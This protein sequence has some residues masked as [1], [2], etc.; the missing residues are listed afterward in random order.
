MRMRMAAWVVACLA[1]LLQGGCLGP[2]GP[3]PWEVARVRKQWVAYFENGYGRTGSQTIRHFDPSVGTAM[4]YRLWQGQYRGIPIA[5]YSCS[6]SKAWG[7]DLVWL[8]IVLATEKAGVR[9]SK[10]YPYYS[11]PPIPRAIVREV[12]EH[13]FPPGEID[14]T[15]ILTEAHRPNSWDVRQVRVEV[16]DEGNGRLGFRINATEKPTW[17]AFD[18]EAALKGEA[19]SGPRAIESLSYPSLT[20]EE[21]AKVTIAEL[22]KWD[23]TSAR[24]WEGF[25]STAEMSQVDHPMW[26]DSGAVKTLL[27]AV[28]VGPLAHAIRVMSRRSAKEPG[29]L[30]RLESIDA[31]LLGLARH[32]AKEVRHAFCQ[33]LGQTELWPRNVH[34]LEPLLMSDDRTVQGHVLSAFTR[35]KESPRRLDRVR[36][37][38]A[39]EDGSV[40]LMAQ[41]VLALPDD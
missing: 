38:A 4:G 10:D 33:L 24:W 30:L 6:F 17:A 32:D 23:T 35:R 39:S 26:D 21:F 7:S 41:R 28:P 2:F 36:E 15:S 14:V 31:T 19:L 20:A 12:A 29:Y 1:G 37:L 34:D 16:R 9:P 22:S 13:R 18:L 11:G 40:R 3:A 27:S 25:P 5:L 8:S